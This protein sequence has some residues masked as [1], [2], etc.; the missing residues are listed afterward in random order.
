MALLKFIGCILG[1]CVIGYIAAVLGEWTL[2]IAKKKG[3]K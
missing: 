3:W 2:E 1:M